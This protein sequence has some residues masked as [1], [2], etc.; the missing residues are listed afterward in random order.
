MQ[1]VPWRFAVFSHKLNS[2]C[3]LDLHLQLQYECLCQL[4]RILQLSF[5][6]PPLSYLS[7]CGQW[8]SFVLALADAEVRPRFCQWRPFRPESWCIWMRYLKWALLQGPCFKEYPTGQIIYK[9]W[10]QFI[11][12]EMLGQSYV[13]SLKSLHY[14]LKTEKI[15]SVSS[16]TNKTEI[17]C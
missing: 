7:D 5:K 10:L 15:A 3:N 1:T 2:T 9:S 17:E 11:S 14:V 8:F 6:F 13:R 4:I 12:L 16:Q